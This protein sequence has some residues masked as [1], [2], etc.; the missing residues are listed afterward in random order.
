MC[1]HMQTYEVLKKNHPCLSDLPGKTG[2]LHLPV[3]PVCN[4]ACRYCE[5]R[6]S[7]SEERPG[8]A[9]RILPVSEVPEII[10]KALSL[11]PEITTVGI[12]GPG[13]A[14]ASEHAV[15]AYRLVD[16]HFP[17]LIKC[18]STNGLML[19]EKAEELSAVR[20]DTITVTVNAV[21]PE[22]EAQINRGIRYKGRLITGEEAAGILIG[23]Q[24]EGIR[25]ASAFGITVKINMVLILGIN[26]RHVGAVAKKTAEAGAK[27]LNIIPLIPQAD[28]AGV[29]APD[30]QSVENARSEAAKHLDVFRHCMHCR[31]DAAG[32]LGE[33]DLRKAL[34]G[35]QVFDGENF[36]HG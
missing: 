4:L 19:P 1:D 13:E 23:N 12:A 34:Y 35:D 18:L 2:R 31:A 5:R 16:R 20:L 25:K 27:I 26:D 22:I 15:E 28:L 6:L 29:P 17:D 7:S 9:A 33:K 32:K 24:L 21:D 11:C 3:S 30:C 10:R 8:T 36:S 14:L